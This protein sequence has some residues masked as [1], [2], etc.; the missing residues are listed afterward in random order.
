MRDNLTAGMGVDMISSRLISEREV[1]QFEIDWILEV[2]ISEVSKTSAR[3]PLEGG[4]CCPWD[5]ELKEGQ[6]WS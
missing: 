6:D 4:H 5:R 3:L 1:P 2:R